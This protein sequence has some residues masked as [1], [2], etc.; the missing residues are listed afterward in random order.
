MA[1]LGVEGSRPVSADRVEGLF[2]LYAR[3][4][5]AFAV[6][7][8]PDRQSAE[9]AVAETFSVAWRRRDSIPEAPLPW[10]YAVAL[11]VLS[12]QRRSERRRFNLRRRVEGSPAEFGR[13]PAELIEHR[14]GVRAAF[15]RLS[16]SQREVLRLTF[17]ESLDPHDASSVLGCSEGAYRVR[18]HR[19]RRDLAKHLDTAGQIA[20]EEPKVMAERASQEAR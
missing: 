9:D 7:R 13:D 11:K 18:L 8:A 20:D 5:L 17:W 14:D 6:R 2:K 3:D 19:A 4:I 10:L 16:E 1:E 15:L 12:N